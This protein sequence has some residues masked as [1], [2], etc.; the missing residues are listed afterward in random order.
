MILYVLFFIITFIFLAFTIGYPV[1]KKLI[2]KDRINW[3]EYALGAN[4]IALVLNIINILI[5]IF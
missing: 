5:Q 1:Y 4:A 3:L 2:K